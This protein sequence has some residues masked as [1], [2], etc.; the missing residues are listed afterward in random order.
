MSEGQ[1]VLHSRT[2]GEETG[3]SAELISALCTCDSSTTNNLA[4]SV[5]SSAPR[6]VSQLG[7][8]KVRVARS[9]YNVIEIAS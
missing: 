5:V 2:R 4:M 1:N 6:C 8:E 9:R 7:V 3:A